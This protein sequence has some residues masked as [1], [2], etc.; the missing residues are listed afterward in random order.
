MAKTAMVFPVLSLLMALVLV[1]VSL[2]LIGG[3]VQ[4]SN[5][6]I[7]NAST[8]S[9]TEANGTVSASR[10]WGLWS[11]RVSMNSTSV[12]LGGAVVLS[13]RLTYLGN[14]NTTMEMVSDVSSASVYD[15]TGAQVWEWTPSEVTWRVTVYPGETFGDNI[16]IPTAIL[17][18]TAENLTHCPFNFREAPVPGVYSVVAAPTVYSSNGQGLGAD[19]GGNLKISLTFTITS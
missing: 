4:G 19:L 5:V 8:T 6:G 13:E 10:T 16:C 1:L 18:A 15:S 2:P 12:R 3:P 17:N 14:A 7:A 11:F 9:T